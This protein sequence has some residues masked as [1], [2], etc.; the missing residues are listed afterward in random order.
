MGYVCLL[1]TAQLL[2]PCNHME[3]S[4][5]YFLS[6][7]DFYLALFQFVLFLSQG[8]AKNQASQR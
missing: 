3:N 4:Q 7:L 6:H 2:R 8:T 5:P 1:G